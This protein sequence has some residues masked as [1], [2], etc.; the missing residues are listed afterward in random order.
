MP[1]SATTILALAA[2]VLIGGCADAPAGSAASKPADTAGDSA[3]ASRGL[4]TQPEPSETAGDATD[5]ADAS[6][7]AVDAAPD[8]T[9]AVIFKAP[10]D[11]P[12]GATCPCTVDEECDDGDPCTFGMACED[13]KCSFGK[14]ENCDDANLCTADSCDLSGQ[15]THTAQDHWCEDGDPCSL[16]DTCAAKTC[17]AGKPAPCDDGNGC[18]TDTCVGGQGCQFAATTAKC[19]DANDCVEASYCLLGGCVQGKAKACDDG[20]ACTYEDCDPKKGCAFIALPT[21]ATTCDGTV[22]DGWCFVAKKGEATWAQ[23]RTA[24]QAWGGD[25]GTLR[26]ADDNALAR[27]LGD[28]A[29]GKVPLWIGLSDRAQEGKFVWTSGHKGGYSNWNGNEP[30]DS[31]GEDVVEQV[32]EGGWND[33]PESAGRPCA[34]CSRPMAS[35]C[36]DGEP[37]TP[38]GLCAQGQCAAPLAAPATVDCDD[39]NPCTADG[40]AVG[41]GCGHTAVA[42]DSPCGGN[43]QCKAG[44]CLAAKPAD[45]ALAPTSCAALGP[46]GPN[47]VYWIDP[48]GKAGKAPAYQAY[49]D[50]AAGGWALVLKVDGN[51]PDSAY[52]SPLWTDATPTANA[53]AWPDA[54]TARLAGYTTL[55]VSQVRVTLVSAGQPRSLVLPAKAANLRALLTGA[56]VKTTASVLQ[57]EALL[58]KGSLQDH[59][60]LQGFHVAAPN[61]VKV[62]IG[63]LGNNEKD[64]GSVDSWLGVGAT[65]NICGA[66]DTPGVGNLACWNPDWGDA[67]TAALA[68]I[69]VR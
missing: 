53:T 66:K 1:R 33:L 29:C 64:C 46:D 8:V 38:P 44:F 32:P 36:D 37:C 22:A 56:A 61:G 41:L 20:K 68:W 63:I 11:C 14:P 39:A 49:C 9:P 42:D 30:N 26:S 12:G 35:A 13:G 45:L 69:W 25:L 50:R 19:A 58:P 67:K 62:R 6:A 31:G 23:A 24:C 17:V 18:T 54:S 43:G 15:C 27:K 2:L 10:G 16:G 57:W 28:A 65:A 40:C 59:C 52:G 48:D 4:D 60:L 7:D 34:V 21:P 55:G 47:G 51:Q 5:T 3:D